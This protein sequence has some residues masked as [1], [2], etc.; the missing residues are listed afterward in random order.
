MCDTFWFQGHKFVCDCS[1]DLGCEGTS[2]EYSVGTERVKDVKDT[3]TLISY[4]HTLENYFHK[5]KNIKNI[6]L[7]TKREKK[8]KTRT[9][10]NTR[11]SEA[12]QP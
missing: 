1:V 3:Y 11:K 5:N 4:K 8:I 12:K 2:Y 6:L 10:S 7:K 9:H